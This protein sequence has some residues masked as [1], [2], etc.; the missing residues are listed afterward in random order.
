MEPAL[1][2]QYVVISNIVASSTVQARLLGVQ[3]H[4]TFEAESVEKR[5]KTRQGSETG[6]QQTFHESRSCNDVVRVS[7]RT[8]WRR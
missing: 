4:L 8:G 2:N 5:N 7:D 1:S 3:T 6:K